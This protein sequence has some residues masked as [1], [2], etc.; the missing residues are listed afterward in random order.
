LAV[1]RI[2]DRLCLRQHLIHADVSEI[3]RNLF[4]TG[5]LE[6]RRDSRP[7]RNWGPEGAH[8]MQLR[9]QVRLA[10]LSST[11]LVLQ[12]IAANGTNFLSGKT[13]QK[14]LFNSYILSQNACY[15]DKT[16][17]FIHV[18]LANLAGWIGLLQTSTVQIWE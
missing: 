15:C 18:D 6:S 13:R 17:Q 9:H 16:L 11:V 5:D 14:N 1:L 4:Q 2:R 10:K 3:Q 7:A 12:T 8:R